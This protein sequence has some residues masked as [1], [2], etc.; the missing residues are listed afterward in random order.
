MEPFGVNSSAEDGGWGDLLPNAVDVAPLGAPEAPA[1]C[2][3]ARTHAGR[4]LTQSGT[5]SRREVRGRGPGA[6]TGRLPSM[7]GILL[8]GPLPGP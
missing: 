4:M 1:D 3:E 2:G 5:A 7:T 8:Y 6:V